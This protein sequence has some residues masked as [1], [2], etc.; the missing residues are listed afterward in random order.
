MFTIEQIEDIHRRL[1]NAETLSDYVRSL[2]TLGRAP[3][4]H[5]SSQAVC[6]GPRPGRS[7]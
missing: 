2:A 6:R 3:R 4:R 5:A 1:G 7:M